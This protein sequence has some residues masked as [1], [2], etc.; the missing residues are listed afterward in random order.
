MLRNG[1]VKFFRSVQDWEYYKDPVVSRLFYHLLIT[2]NIKD[3]K[4]Q[5]VNVPAGS[6][7]CTYPMLAKEL[8]G[9]TDKQVRTAI[10]KLERSDSITKTTF[11]KFSIVC[12]NNWNEYQFEGRQMGSQRAD[13]WAVKKQS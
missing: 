9:V 13:R 10:E 12:I 3:S 2:V 4:Y 5:G 8:G 11:T 7:V 1:Y 6:R